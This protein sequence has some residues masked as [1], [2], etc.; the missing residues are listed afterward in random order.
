MKMALLY[1][2]IVL[3]LLFSYICALQYLGLISEQTPAKI[4]QAIQQAEIPVQTIYT[5]N[6]DE[7]LVFDFL[8]N[9]QKSLALRE[10]LRCSTCIINGNPYWLESA[11]LLPSLEDQYAAI[12]ALLKILSIS[13]VLLIRGPTENVLFKGNDIISTTLEVSEEISNHALEL[14]ARRVI[15]AQSVRTLVLCAEGELALRLLQ[16]LEASRLDYPITILLVQKA[17]WFNKSLTPTLPGGILFITSQG[18]ESA[19]SLTSVIACRIRQRIADVL[20]TSSFTVLQLQSESSELVGSVYQ[21][22][23]FLCFEC[24]RWIPVSPVVTKVATLRFSFNNGIINPNGVIA[25][26][27]AQ[28]YWGADLAVADINQS[29]ELLPFC[30]LLIFNVSLGLFEFNAEWAR[31]QLAQVTPADLGL[32]FL[33]G[34]YSN[35]AIPL[36]SFL[37][38]FNFTRP[39]IAADNSSPLL[40]AATFPHYA[41]VTISSAYVG[42]MYARFIKH[43]GWTR[44][45][46]LHCDDLYCTQLAKVLE[47]AATEYGLEIVTNASTRMLPTNMTS[48]P[49]DYMHVFRE[50]VDSKVRIVVL[51]MYG[52]TLT[53]CIEALYDLGMRRGDLLFLPVMWLVP[54]LFDD[55]AEDVHKRKELLSGALQIYPGAFLGPLG[56]DIQTRFQKVY[57]MEPAHFACTNYDAVLLLAHCLDYLRARGAAY[58]DTNVLSQELRKARFIGC[59]GEVTL[60]EGERLPAVFDITNVVVEESGKVT[61]L[62]VGL[63]KPLSTVLLSFSRNVTWPD[64]TS[65]VPGDT[66]VNLLDCPFEYKDM[67]E[68]WP[69]KALEAGSFILFG[70]LGLLVTV[71]IWRKCWHKGALAMQGRAEISLEDY[72]LYAAIG[73][74]GVQYCYLGPHLQE[75]CFE[76]QRFLVFVDW[77]LRRLFVH[78]R[79]LLIISVATSLGAVGLWIGLL[80]AAALRLRCTLAQLGYYLL[81]QLGNVCF[82]PI[83]VSLLSLLQCGQAASPQDSPRL[84]DTYVLED[85][86]LQCWGGLH[87]GLTI[88]ALLALAVYIPSAVYL[89]PKWQE[90][91][92]TLHIPVSPTHLMVKSLYQLMTVINQKELGQVSPLAH[93]IVFFLLTICYFSTSI[94]WPPYGYGRAN[95][96]HIVSIICVLWYS[97]IMSISTYVDTKE[98]V[99]VSVLISGLGLIVA[100]AL[101]LQCLC[102]PSQLYRKK[103]I[104]IVDLFRFQ[105]SEE[106]QAHSLFVKNAPITTVSPADVHICVTTSNMLG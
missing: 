101:L 72:L 2:T 90:V 39:Q 24:L 49:Y 106:P 79:K 100:V 88:P 57:G 50:L 30:K 67:R 65:I 51:A 71:L 77:D 74:E 5:E 78:S 19:G 18:C 13:E 56:R 73:A 102:I 96:W 48:Y 98:L 103:G 38:S 87:L 55:A 20:E 92:Q 22:H 70:L 54:Q 85:C 94:L 69:A 27:E 44:F 95:L 31:Q 46:L 59:T 91:Q 81:P 35:V 10:E 93:V 76:A 45:S 80:L 62:K 68:Y 37:T 52:K 64:G 41:R 63:F 40:S 34:H 4:T 15:K 82:L 8:Y 66:R 104:S 84:A 11:A 89:R 75:W 6:L 17:S 7:V 9:R 33:H 28:Y 58:E 105:F 97:L 16:V 23:A 99:W 32:A 21:D 1:M 60:Q 14:L 43:Y 42:V 26:E 36:Y 3:W 47:Q 83:L 53:Y 61:I 25:P 29:T 12:V 86:Y